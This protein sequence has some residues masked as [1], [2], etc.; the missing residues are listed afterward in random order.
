M[1]VWY[2]GTI[3]PC[4]TDYMSKLKKGNVADKNIIDIWKSKDYSKLR[5]IH[6]NKKRKILNPCKRCVVV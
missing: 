1:F 5:E 2:D 4:D 6:L 3:N